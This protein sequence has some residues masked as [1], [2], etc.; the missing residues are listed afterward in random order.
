MDEKE[1]SIETCIRLK[2]D[3]GKWYKQIVSSKVVCREEGLYVKDQD[4][5]VVIDTFNKSLY[6]A[7]VLGRVD[8][9]MKLSNGCCPFILDEDQRDEKERIKQ[10]LI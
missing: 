4:R 7:L 1:V 2:G 10:D 9:G 8:L 6:G 5:I 3:D